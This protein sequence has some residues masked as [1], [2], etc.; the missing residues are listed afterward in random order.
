MARIISLCNQKGGVGK[1][2]STINL[3]VFLA[4]LGKKVLIVDADP[5]ANTTSG[6]GL[7]PRKIDKSIYHVLIG[8]TLAEPVIKKTPILSVD[9]LPSSPALAGAAIELVD[10]KNREY[11]LKEGLILTL[12]KEEELILDNKKIIIKPVWK[13]LLEIY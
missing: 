9:I 11:K 6:I 10:I 8:K 7:N 5:Q 12:D 1:S 2:T 3:G 13:W 4:A